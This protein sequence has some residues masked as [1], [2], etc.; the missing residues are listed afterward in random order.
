M[1]RLPP[2]PRRFEL[3]LFALVALG[4]A[5]LAALVH[6]HDLAMAIFALPIFVFAGWMGMRRSGQWASISVPT[7]EPATALADELDEEE[8]AV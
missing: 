8:L 1:K 4:C 6:A 7:Q 3:S 2:L 5:G